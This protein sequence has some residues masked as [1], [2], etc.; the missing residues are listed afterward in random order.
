[1]KI[2]ILCIDRDDDL[3]RKADI[4]GPLIGEKVVLGA[5]VKLL[6]KDPSETDAN[7]MFSAL[8]TF[9]EIKE[10]KKQVA[11]LT[12][13]VK[14]GYE[15]DKIIG[16][17]LD[18]VLKKFPADGII[19]V[20]DGKEDEL[21]VP[22]IESKAPIISVQRLVVDSGQELK[23]AFYTLKSF[24]SRAAEDGGLAMSIFGLPA[25]ALLIFAF[26]GMQG[27]RIFLGAVGIY[28]GIK[29]LKVE[30]RIISLFKYIRTSFV[31]LSISFLLYSLSF[32]LFIITIIKTLGISGETVLIKF[33]NI[34][35]TASQPFFYSMLFILLG[36]AVDALPDRRTAYDYVT[37]GVSLGVVTLVLRHFG[38]W[39]LDTTYPLSYVITTTILGSIVV[40]VTKL[41]GKFISK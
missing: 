40:I 28:L 26:F 15:S 7:A 16:K 5:A 30:A 17:Q 35:L 11:V 38:T 14:V 18:V 23:G 33:A 27:W 9:D 24:F 29:A 19:L 4:K 8:K 13:S 6:R 1:M 32:I 12:G 31:S 39:L 36:V 2:L 37:M 41:A 21:L 34:L 10:K 25:L 3:G 22:V 20:G